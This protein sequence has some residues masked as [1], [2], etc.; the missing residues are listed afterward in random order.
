MG[1]FLP[2]GSPLLRAQQDRTQTAEK[3]APSLAGGR[4][5]HTL[6]TP[7]APPGGMGSEARE[8]RIPRLMSLPAACPDTHTGSPAWS[9]PLPQAPQRVWRGVGQVEAG[10][11]RAVPVF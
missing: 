5:A 11:A 10:R 4:G 3:P 6:P 9:Q 1:K 2:A 8:E 7:P